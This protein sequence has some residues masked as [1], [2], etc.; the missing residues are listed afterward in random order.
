MSKNF[1]LYWSSMAKMEDCPQGFLWGRGWG[2][3]DVGGGPGRRK[4]VIKKRSEHHAVMGIAIQYVIERFYNDELWKFLRGRQLQKRLL[5][6]TEKETNRLLAKKYIDW[7]ESPPKDDL[8]QIIRD[9]VLGYLHTLKKHRLLGEYAQ[10][11]VDLVGYVDKWNPIGGRADMIIRRP[12]T[13]VTILDGKNSKRY[14]D[15]KTGGWMTF[16][17]PDQLRWYALC[18]YIIYKKLPDRL[19]F[20]YFRYPAGSPV[21][22][23]SGKDTGEL[24][25][26]I[27]WVDCTMEDVKGLAQRALDARKQMNFEKFPANPSYQ[28]CKFCDYETVCPERQ[29]TKRKRGHRKQVD[30]L[31]GQGG[32][33]GIVSLGFG[34]PKKT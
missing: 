32:K 3:I 8:R 16:T 28:T 24:E 25:E 10:A 12:D 7:T 31:G 20:V 9:G 5:E 23:P 33:G 18:Y 27:D 4:P 19:G 13:G 1:T 26:G 21:I 15:K 2:T 34:G 11:E 22:D 17:D 6:L 30:V 14:K 29:A